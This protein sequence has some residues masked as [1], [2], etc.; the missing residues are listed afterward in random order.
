MSK[1]NE[2]PQLQKAIEWI[3]YNDEPTILDIDEIKDLVSVSMASD[4]YDIPTKEIAK[5]ILKLRNDKLKG[6]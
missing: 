1:K 2:D 3:A 5:R 4:L 6:Q